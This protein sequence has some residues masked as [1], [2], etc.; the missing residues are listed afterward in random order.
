MSEDLAKISK[1]PVWA[2]N[3]ISRLRTRVGELEENV[4]ALV[5]EMPK[6]PIAVRNIYGR[7]PCL[8]HGGLT[9]PSAS[10]PPVNRSA[11]AHPREKVSSALAW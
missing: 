10:R 1:L 8:W 9:R 5:G 2:Q 3:E 7:T 6:E 11:R 4:S